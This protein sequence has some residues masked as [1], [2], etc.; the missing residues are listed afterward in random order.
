M[1]NQQPQDRTHHLR[2]EGAQTSPSVADEEP[3]ADGV[4]DNQGL[5][6]SATPDDSLDPPILTG[7][8]RAVLLVDC[9]NDASALTVILRE[10]EDNDCQP[11]VRRAYG[12]WRTGNANQQRWA[13]Q[14]VAWALDPIQVHGHNH[15]TTAGRNTATLIRMSID[16]VQLA[17]E[18]DLTHF[19]IL[20]NSPHLAP[21][22]LHLRE[23]EKQLIVVGT[24]R[25]R[26]PNAFFDLAW[27]REILVEH[28]EGE[29]ASSQSSTTRADTEPT[30]AR[31]E[32]AGTHQLAG[33][34]DTPDQQKVEELGGVPAPS[35]PSQSDQS[36][37]VPFVRDQCLQQGERGMWLPLTK[38]GDL[39]RY[40]F[41]DYDP[42]SHG[43]LLQL[44]KQRPD[45][46]DI[47]P[48]PSRSY[49][50]PV[51]HHIKL[52][53]QRL[54]PLPEP[55]PRERRPPTPRPGQPP[56][57]APGGYKTPRYAR[58][59]DYDTGWGS[60]TERTWIR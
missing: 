32:V 59:Q 8:H 23:R 5:D 21:L 6:D 55:Q 36:W 9:G 54:P 57:N 42:A 49:S 4:L 53:Q 7:E 60:D 44:V 56:R 38:L 15:H 51:T 52:R 46:F 10:I 29:S 50:F 26:Q 1:A 3:N 48:D 41:P 40:T 43:R 47:H 14:C 34:T 16:A 12:D 33:E 45:L 20:A 27:H 18:E 24:T 22:A 28:P 17:E 58:Q 11:V 39:L 37:W 13:D 31:E 30:V 35:M 19:F 2:A 25:S